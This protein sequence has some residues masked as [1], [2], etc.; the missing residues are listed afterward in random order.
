MGFRRRILVSRCAHALAKSM[1]FG[2][3][4]HMRRLCTFAIP[5]VLVSLGLSSCYTLGQLGLVA[6]VGVRSESAANYDWS[7]VV[8]EP[9]NPTATI[10]DREF[11]VISSMVEIAMEQRG[12]TVVSNDEL[13]DLIVFISYETSVAPGATFG[14]K[15]G[16]S[17]MISA[18]DIKASLE[19]EEIVPAW[20]TTAIMFR[21]NDSFG[22]ALPYL[23]VA[24]EPY[25]GRF[26]HGLTTLYLRHG[27]RSLSQYEQARQLEPLTP[28]FDPQ[29]IL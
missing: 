26:S 11:R 23:L 25:I 4:G 20:E 14:R 1:V 24:A 18:Y 6:E 5:I 27:D 19:F 22:D 28:S 17:L 12:F 7:R 8:L 15:F 3:P 16:H 9:G 21:R 2:E 10:S 13:A 29:E